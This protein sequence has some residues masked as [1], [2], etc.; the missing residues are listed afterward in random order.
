M[1]VSFSKYHE[2]T[3]ENVLILHFIMPFDKQNKQIYVE[4][5]LMLSTGGVL[6]EVKR[7][8]LK[9]PLSET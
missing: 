8:S 7:K 6:N 3:F 1:V 4:W 5:L 9:I 2:V